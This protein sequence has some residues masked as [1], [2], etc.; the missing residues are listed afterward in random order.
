MQSKKILSPTV[1]VF[2]CKS[3]C[4]NV[5]IIT[6]IISLL[7]YIFDMIEW[8]RL[9]S[10]EHYSSLTVFSILKLSIYQNYS[11]VQRISPII[12][13][14]ASTITYK[15][16]AKQN[17]IIAL[18]SLGFSD[19][20]IIAP[21]IVGLIGL[22]IVHFMILMPLSAIFTDLASSYQHKRN[23]RHTQ[24]LVNIGKNGLWIKAQGNDGR[25]FIIN[26]SKINPVNRTLTD[27]KIFNINNQWNFDDIIIAP[28]LKIGNHNLTITDA[29]V[30]RSH[31]VISEN[32]I[33]INSNIKF[34]S[35]VDSLIVP[36]AIQFWELPSV[37]KFT[38]NFGLSAFSYELYYYKQL[39]LPILWTL[40]LIIGY[41]YTRSYTQRYTNKIQAYGGALGILLGFL[42]FVMFDAIMLINTKT[43]L[44][45]KYRTILAL[46]LS[47]IFTLISVCI[48]QIRMKK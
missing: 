31:R 30:I 40:M 9:S 13:I 39:S 27:V 2:I 1:T 18:K 36:E 35:I 17:T 20:Q 45:V 46:L 34:D 10:K 5:A 19:L 14:L 8:I 42:V 4:L 47:S 48:Y 29:T 6:A 44:A 21:S 23:V 12:I 43:E 15:Q 11:I 22:I 41:I 24:T 28:S 33:I 7:V 16:L 3:F 26:A 38:R 37:I 25:K 32:Q